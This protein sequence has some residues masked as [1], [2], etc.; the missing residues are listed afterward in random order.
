M[1]NI[2]DIIEKT[3]TYFTNILGE[4]VDFRPVSKGMLGMI[5]MTISSI[6]SFYEGDILGHRLILAYIGDG[7]SVPPAQMKKLLDI[8][9]R[10]T[11]HWAVLVTPCISS[12]NKLRL[13]AQKVN[14]VI[15]NGQMFLPSLLLEIKPEKAVGADLKETIPPF[16]QLLLLY[17]LQV[18]SVAGA[19][20]HELS[21]RFSVSYSTVNKAIRWMTSKDLIRM[22]G[23][24]TKTI[25]A[26]LK[27]RDLWEKAL[28]LLG[29]PVEQVVYTDAVLN[30]QMA[31]GV[32]ALSAYTM[33]NEEPHRCYAVDKNGMKHIGVEY[34]KRF[35]DNKIEVWKYAPRVLSAT[36]VVDRLSLYLSLKDEKDD[37]I[38]I[39][40]QRLIDE[41]RWSED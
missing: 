41:M 26:T 5:P 16:A 15:P 28:P 20:C 36:G 19:S 30:H 29:S 9:V 21:N 6:F 22:E 7:D 40:L 35:G 34:D 39:E 33:I 4:N 1:C 32:N 10:Q 38:Q 31:S 12:Y 14:F 13:I 2:K 27:G 17:H 24:K 3:A 23:L 18:A 8:I 11:G 25:Q 37:R